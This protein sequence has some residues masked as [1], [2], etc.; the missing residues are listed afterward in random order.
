MNALPLIARLETFGHSLPVVVAGIA[1]AD[2]VWKPPDGAWSVLEI[3]NHLADED[4]R[5]FRA[6]LS[7]T[8]RDPALPWP[9]GDPQQ[10]A[11]DGR[12]NERDLAESIGRFV[13][14]RRESVRWLR[15]LHTPDWAQ[16]HVH[17]R[18]GPLTAGSLLGAWAAHDALHLRQIA[19]RMHE[20]A[21]RQFRGSPPYAGGQRA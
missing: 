10:W 20:L 15:S 3:V 6:R 18:A 13:A 12:Y 16:A 21:G 7:L 9:P 4:P 14:E 2:A 8:L 5:D 19:K 1:A 17:P 11:R